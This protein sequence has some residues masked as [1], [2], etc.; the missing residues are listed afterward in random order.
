M[1]LYDIYLNSLQVDGCELF[2]RMI[3]ARNEDNENTIVV[4]TQMLSDY[5]YPV[6]V[7]EKKILNLI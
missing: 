4:N 3:N 6:F 5:K 7:S 1:V 2:Y